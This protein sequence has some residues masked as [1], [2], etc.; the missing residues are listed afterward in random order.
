[1]NDEEEEDDEEEEAV[2]VVEAVV[3][4]DVSLPLD[5]S[6]RIAIRTSLFAGFFPFSCGLFPNQNQL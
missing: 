2:S 5:N 1:M 3:S 4:K 6:S